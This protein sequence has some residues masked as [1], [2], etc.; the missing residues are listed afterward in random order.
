MYIDPFFV[1]VITTILVEVIL[2]IGV[3][4]LTGNKK[5]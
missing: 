3:A 4:I 2:F 5:K 1:G